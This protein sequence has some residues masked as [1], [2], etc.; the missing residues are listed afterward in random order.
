MSNFIGFKKRKCERLAVLVT[1][2]HKAQLPLPKTD[3]LPSVTP[4]RKWWNHLE[5]E[6]KFH[7]VLMKLSTRDSCLTFILYKG[8]L[9]PAF[10]CL[11]YI[12]ALPSSAMP[13]QSSKFRASA[14]E[15][16]VWVCDVHM[17][18][19]VQRHTHAHNELASVSFSESTSLPTSELHLKSGVWWWWWGGCWQFC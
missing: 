1:S 5:V 6:I 8:F 16:L 9:I 10:R 13:T 4:G 7:E 11:Q 15:K 12:E 3:V 17:H 2:R 18:M 19:C 14:A